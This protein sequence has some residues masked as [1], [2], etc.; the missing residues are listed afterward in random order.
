MTNTLPQ[1]YSPPDTDASTL[2]LATTNP[3]KLAEASDVMAALGITVEGVSLDLVEPMVERMES[4]AR[5]KARQAGDLLNRPVVV[6]EA[7][8]F[9]EAYPGFPGPF[10]K[11]VVRALGYEGLTRLLDGC[12]RR[13]ELK[14]VLAYW[15]PTLG[16]EIQLFEGRCQGHLLAEPRGP[17]RSAT[18][19]SRIFVPDGHTQPLALL[20][21][22]ALREVSHRARALHQLASYLGREDR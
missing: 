13:A 22:E 18:P 7:G 17:E 2:T 14:A 5:H 11:F 10:T 20:E 8:L 16:G 19:L 12:S 1:D 4:I 6:D 9:L 15:T 3:D 21:P